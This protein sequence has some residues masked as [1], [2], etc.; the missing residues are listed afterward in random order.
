MPEVQRGNAGGVYS[1]TSPSCALDCRE[2]RKILPG[3]HQGR[4]PGASPHRKL[5]LFGVRLSRIVCTGENQLTR[6]LH[7]S[8]ATFRLIMRT[9]ANRKAEKTVEVRMNVS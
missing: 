1:R 9:H 3:G 8:S 2:A 4:R 5:P 7:F 6:A